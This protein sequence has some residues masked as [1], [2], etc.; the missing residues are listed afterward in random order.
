MAFINGTDSRAQANTVTS[1]DSYVARVVFAVRIGV[2]RL[3]GNGQV[4]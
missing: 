1:N 3:H 2:G 4:Y